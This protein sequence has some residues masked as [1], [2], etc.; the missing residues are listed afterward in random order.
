MG[1]HFFFNFVLQRFRYEFTESTRNNTNNLQNRK[2]SVLAIRIKV[3]HVNRKT[4]PIYTDKVFFSFRHKA[5]HKTNKLY[6]M[7]FVSLNSPASCRVAQPLYFIFYCWNGM[8][9]KLSKIWI[10]I[11]IKKV[12]SIQSYF[13]HPYNKFMF[14]QER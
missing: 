5:S 12:I 9:Q 14:W 11:K 10:G 13:Y 3:L 8:Q 6:D 1:N 7:T 2:K 4:S